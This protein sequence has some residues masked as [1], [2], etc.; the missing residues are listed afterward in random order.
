MPKTS[1]NARRQSQG[2]IVADIL[3]DIKVVNF[4]PEQPCRG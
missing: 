3:L 2:R 1:L 4:R